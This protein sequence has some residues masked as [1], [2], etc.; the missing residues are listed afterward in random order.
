MKEILQLKFTKQQLIQMDACR[1]YLK[2]VYL[3][4]IATPDRTHILEEALSY[5]SQSIITSKIIFHV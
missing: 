3:S 5:K 2:I 4:N 1:I